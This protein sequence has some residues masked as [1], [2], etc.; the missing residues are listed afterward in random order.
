[1]SLKANRMFGEKNPQWKGDEVKYMGL[2]GWIYRK[3]GK[4]SKCIICNKNKKKYYWANVSGK[5]LR[6]TNDF[7]ELCASCHVRYDRGLIERGNYGRI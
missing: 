3:L 1:M 7:M 6:N 4:A 2:H 5:Y